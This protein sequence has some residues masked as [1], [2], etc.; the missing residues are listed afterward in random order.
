ME[1]TTKENK[2]SESEEEIKKKVLSDKGSESR[3]KKVCR[4]CGSSENSK[5]GKRKGVQ[6]YRCKDCGFQFTK[7]TERHS[8]LDERRAI[9]LYC[10]GFSFRTIG[11]LMNWHHTTIMRWVMR[12]AKWHY[13]KPVP[14]GE[15]LV[16]LDEMHHYVRSKKNSCGYGKHIVEQMDNYLTGRWEIEIPRHLQGC[17]TD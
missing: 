13:Q 10:L 1:V 2:K 3:E 4:V 14:K 15:I 17:M 5:W 8:E 11:K 6:C 9:T 7:E 12:F 16:E